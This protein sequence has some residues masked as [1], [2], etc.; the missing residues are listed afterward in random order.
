V[1]H[2]GGLEA[3]RVNLT[4]LSGRTPANPAIGRYADVGRL[5]AGKAMPDEEANAS[6]LEN[7]ED[8]TRRL[9]LPRLGHYGIQDKDIERIVANSRGSS[10]KTNPVT[11]TDA[12]IA[13]IVRARL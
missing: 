4:A 9:K 12:E 13:G 11:L 10:M 8:W 6:L 2:P 7:L 1:R 5:L 3:T